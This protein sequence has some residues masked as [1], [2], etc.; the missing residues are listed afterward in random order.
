MLA[1]FSPENIQ[2]LVKNQDQGSFFLDVKGSDTIEVVKEKIEGIKGI[3]RKLQLL[4]FQG[5]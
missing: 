2:I 4:S 3:E 1:T 5:E